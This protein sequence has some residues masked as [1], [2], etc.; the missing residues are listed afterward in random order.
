Y[1]RFDDFIETTELADSS[2]LRLFTY[3]NIEDGA[4]WGSELELGTTWR[5][6]RAE[7]GYGYLVAENRATGERLPGRPTHAGRG[8][9]GYARASG[10]RV[11]LTGVYTGSAVVT[12]TDSAETERAGFGR[13]DVRIAQTLPRGLEVSAGV[14]NLA[15][16]RPEL[17]PGY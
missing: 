7:A 17:W 8:S 14:D 5:G 3:G 13:L 9:I 11:T 15:D 2:G 12:R 6:F 16:T 10:L 1:N 4:T